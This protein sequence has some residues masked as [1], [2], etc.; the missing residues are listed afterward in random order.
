LLGYILDRVSLA[1]F[2][3]TDPTNAD[4]ECKLAAIEVYKCAYTSAL[5]KSLETT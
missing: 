4:V 1:N 2:R 3:I 5:L